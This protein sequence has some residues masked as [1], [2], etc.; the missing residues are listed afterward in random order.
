MNSKN[1]KHYQKALRR[2]PWA[3][4]TNAKRWYPD[5]VKFM[6]PFIKRAKGCRL[7][8]L[9]DREYIDYRCALGPII[10]GYGY[11]EVETA[12]R[13]Q[14]KSGVLFSMA[15]PIELETAEAIIENV[16]WLEQIRFM[17]TGADACSSCVRLA[18]AYTRRDHILTSGYHGYHDWFV[19]NW[20]N[21]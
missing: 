1:A 5:E 2:I 18:R 21:S 19:L 4:Q 9:D 17:K 8:D 3:T 14:M 10:L 15:S 11:P 12:V 7:W 13:E 6:P 20:P 16:P